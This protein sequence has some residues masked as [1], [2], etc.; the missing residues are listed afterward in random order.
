MKSSFSRR[1]HILATISICQS[2]W[3]KYC[4]LGMNSRMW[5]TGSSISSR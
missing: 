3:K 2:S 4:V 1:G 5:N